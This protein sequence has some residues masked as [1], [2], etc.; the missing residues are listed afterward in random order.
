MF[1]PFS[2]MGI[3]DYKKH[4]HLGGENVFQAPRFRCKNAENDDECMKCFNEETKKNQC[5]NKSPGFVFQE[6]I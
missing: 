6:F 2:T 3:P 4:H 5:F 1:D